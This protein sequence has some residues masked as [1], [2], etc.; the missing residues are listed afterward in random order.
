[1]TEE[2]KWTLRAPFE[3]E[4]V[5][6]KSVFLARAH[7]VY[8]EEELPKIIQSLSSATATH[9]CWACRFG[10]FFRCDDAGEPSGTAGRPILQV[11]DRQ[12]MDQLVIVVSRWFGGIK[13][14]AGGL[15]R[16]Y[17]G[18]AAQCLTLA[19]KQ[20]SISMVN[21]G[22]IGNFSAYGRLQA[23]L[24]RYR[25]EIVSEEFLS[26]FVRFYVK[27]PTSSLE[28]FKQEVQNITRGKSE[29]RVEEDRTSCFR[30]V[31]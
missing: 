9:N 17:S 5:V 22:F 31:E 16:A 14:G 15:V 28:I 18:V 19:E 12:K 11:M 4:L 26:D 30:R 29:F 2:D 13:L 1:M 3:Y 6:K 23:L 24:S 27:I 21:V 20:R 25:A 7:P 8:T 10:D